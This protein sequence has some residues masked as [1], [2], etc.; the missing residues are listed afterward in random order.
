MG[1]PHLLIPFALDSTGSAATVDQDT[2]AEVSQCV[3][4]LLSTPTGTRIV[5]PAYGIPDP[6]FKDSNQTV[7]AIVAAVARYEPRAAGLT[8]NVS[9]NPSGTVSITARLPERH[10]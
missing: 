1:I 9:P 4:V 10:R 2:T 5:E 3:Q 7:A 6:T 8:V